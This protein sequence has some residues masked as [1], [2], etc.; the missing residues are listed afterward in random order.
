MQNSFSSEEHVYTQLA[1]LLRSQIRHG[2]L[3]GKIPGVRDLAQQYSVNAKT[4]NKAVSL[5]VQEGLLYRL[6]GRGTFVVDNAGAHDHTALVGFV[7]TDITN[8]YFAQLAQAIQ[9]QAYEEQISVFVSTNHSSTERLNRIL[10]TYRRRN[11]QLIIVHGGVVR[12]QSALQALVDAGLPLIGVHTHLTTIDDVWPDVRAGAQMAAEH[13]IEQCGPQI[14]LISGSDDPVQETGRFR[15]FRDALMRHGGTVDF[16]YIVETAPTYRGGY[17]AI[18]ALIA[19]GALPKA[20]LF[21][22]QIMAM[23]GV[24]SLIAHGV[25]IPADMAVASI[26]DGIDASQ[27]LLP[28]TTV[29]LPIQETARHVLQLARERIN[30]SEAPPVDIRVMPRLIVRETTMVHPGTP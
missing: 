18:T 1:D 5:L 28:T 15:G 9:T 14:G 24:S 11:V 17:Q 13:L 2:D 16:R 10:E 29:A 4:A 27:M 23:G 21:Y 12:H 26:D 20:L 8:P 30:G 6:Q 19:R 7:I 3:S 22:N 25:E